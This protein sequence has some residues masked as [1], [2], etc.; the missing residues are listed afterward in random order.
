MQLSVEYEHISFDERNYTNASNI[1]S[2]KHRDLKSQS[3]SSKSKLVQLKPKMSN[4]NQLISQTPLSFI[5]PASFPIPYMIPGNTPS[6]GTSCTNFPLSIT[7]SPNPINRTEAICKTSE[8][9]DTFETERIEPDNRSFADG[10]DDPSI[11]YSEDDNA[12]NSSITL[13]LNVVPDDQHV[14]HAQASSGTC[15]PMISTSVVEGVQEGEEHQQLFDN[16]SLQSSPEVTRSGGMRESSTNTEPVCSICFKSGEYSSSSC[17]T[18]SSTKSFWIRCND[19]FC[20]DMV[21]TAC[22]GFVVTH[23]AHL[24]QLPAFYCKAHR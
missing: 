7:V 11:V 8:T 13:S 6:V 5:L 18:D 9:F 12:M 22:V 10:S 21:H 15:S 4:Q 14:V 2:S 20:Y 16:K 19:P 24:K 23:R 1:I 3:T 17:T